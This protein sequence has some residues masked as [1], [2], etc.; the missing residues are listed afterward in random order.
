MLAAY[1][2]YVTKRGYTTVKLN[3]K[4]AKRI[5]FNQKVRDIFAPVIKVFAKKKESGIVDIEDF[6]L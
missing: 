2:T 4:K 1:D 6:A 5:R 3:D